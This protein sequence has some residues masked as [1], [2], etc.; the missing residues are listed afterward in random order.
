MEKRKS[1]KSKWTSGKRTSTRKARKRHQNGTQEPKIGPKKAVNGTTRGQKSSQEGPKRVQKRS[2][3]ASRTKKRTK[4]TPRPSWDSPRGRFAPLSP[5]S[6]G[7]FGRQKTTQNGTENDAKS[8]RKSRSEKKRAKRIK[9]PSW[10]DLG[11]FGGAMW[12]PEDP[13]SIGKHTI[14]CKITFSKI[15]RFEDGSGTNLGRKRRQH[16]RK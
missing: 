15:R 16:D 2:Q 3:T 4:T 6:R 10:S 7:P 14:S 11:R 12:E 8:K 1:S 13:K 5:T 9:D